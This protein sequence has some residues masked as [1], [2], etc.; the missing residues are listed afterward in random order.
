MRAALLCILVV[1]VALGA[2]R[3]VHAQTTGSPPAGT[4]DPNAVALAQAMFLQ[5]QLAL[6]WYVLALA[7]QA[8]AARAS[9]SAAAT[10][11]NG[12]AP[13][14]PSPFKQE[15][16][17]FGAPPGGG[18]ETAAPQAAY[19]AAAPAASSSA[20]AG[21]ASPDASAPPTQEMTAPPNVSASAAPRASESAKAPPLES[22]TPERDDESAPASAP[23]AEL[24]APLATERAST[25]TASRGARG[26]GSTKRPESSS[27]Y[28]TL[29]GFASA[30]ILLG[31]GA[32]AYAAHRIRRRG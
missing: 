1:L 24:A 25:R 3:P 6:Q 10:P 11:T 23:R 29:V 30:A 4:V 7:S 19:P 21:E 5:Q 18:S 31:F 15:P 20:S 9:A 27:P 22:A 14:A 28:A 17:F 16:V 2:S 26:E 13:V 12:F 32:Y 8:P